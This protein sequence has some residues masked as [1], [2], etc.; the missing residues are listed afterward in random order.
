MGMPLTR[1]VPPKKEIYEL[2]NDEKISFVRIA[3]TNNLVFYFHFLIL[4]M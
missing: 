2:S 1:L 3:K 4:V